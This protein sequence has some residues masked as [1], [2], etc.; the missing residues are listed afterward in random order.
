MGRKARINLTRMSQGTRSEFV[1]TDKKK[2]VSSESLTYSSVGVDRYSREELRKKLGKIIEL[3]SRKYTIGNPLR[4]PFGLVF[5]SSPKSE[6]FLDFQIEGVGTKT[7]L[8]EIEPSGYSTI[9]IDGVA[10][11]VNDL[12]RSGANPLFISDAIHIA[13][14]ESDLVR[15]IVSGVIK[16]AQMCGAVL[17]SGETGDV[18]EILHKKI[19][20]K[21][22]QPFDLFVSCCGFGD[23]HNLIMGGI[24]EGDEI[25]GM[26]SSGIHSN[27]VSLARRV[28]L[29]K[30]G[31][32]YDPYDEPGELSKP[33]IKEMLEPT[34]IYAKA[35]NEASKG[36]KIK[37]AVHITGDGFR[38]FYR[39][40]RFNKAIPNSPLKHKTLGFDFE[41]LGEMK[42]IFKLIHETA[43][44]SS[45]HLALKE[46]YQTFN[47]GYGFAA[48][49]DRSDLENAL[50][51]FNKYHPTR[52]IGR[53]T[54]KGMI[55]IDGVT[56]SKK[57]LIL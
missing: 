6:I 21:E 53:V 35:I 28:L 2:A 14:S 42:P 4:L 33:L 20:P 36:L 27:G 3:E 18:S 38:K 43:A 24:N 48:I 17:A 37:A 39:L 23:S 25:V 56:P 34:R 55:K 8:A 16:G 12:I 31:G 10:M 45:K 41:D 7:L 5:C 32:R 29:R 57:A 15:K 26:E 50:D 51:L 46:M 52:R 19:G 1:S 40:S 44:Q 47:M 9:G 13:K 22:S 54:T 30:W 11:A 49:I